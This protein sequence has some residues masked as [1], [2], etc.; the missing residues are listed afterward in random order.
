MVCAAVDRLDVRAGHSAAARN[1]DDVFGARGLRRLDD[2]DLLSGRARVVP[3][4]DKDALC[5]RERLR[6]AGAIVELGYRCLRARPEH[7]SCLVRIANDGDGPL[8][9]GLELLD[10]CAPGISGCTDDCIHD[11]P[12][13]GARCAPFDIAAHASGSMLTRQSRAA[14]PRWPPCRPAR[15]ALD[16]SLLV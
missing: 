9:E 16:G 14:G 6:H 10:H 15:A 4:D 2:I 11:D 1:L 7:F 12:P 13:L 5:P 8:A 3:G